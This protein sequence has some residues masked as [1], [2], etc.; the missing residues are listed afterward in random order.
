[1][2]LFLKLSPIIL[3][4]ALLLFLVSKFQSC[5]GPV[6]VIKHGSTETSVTEVK[7]E[8]PSKAVE[9]A[10][11]TTEGKDVTI[12]GTIKL[13]SMVGDDKSR[14][15]TTTIALISDCITCT[16][17]AVL[18]EESKTFVG[19]SFRSKLYLGYTNDSTTLGY[20]QEFF[21]Y[22]KTSV[23]G[24]ATLPYLGLGASYDLTNNF[25]ALGGLNVQYLKYNKMEDI[26]SYHID[27]D[28]L[29]KPYPVVA[30]GFYF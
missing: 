12:T 20:A 14:I 10:V 16:A 15:K 30:I 8:K 6:T 18:V 3:I 23:N 28:E 26:G 29:K 11:R 17:R 27:L 24:L 4:L 7:I 21:R 25:F 1:M 9:D 13:K 5:G 22:G 2:N 19:F